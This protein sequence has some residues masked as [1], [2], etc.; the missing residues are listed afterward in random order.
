MK[1]DGK[2]AGSAGETWWRAGSV[3]P[4]GVNDCLVSDGFF[5]SLIM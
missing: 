2:G 1:G 4:S 3:S 5:L